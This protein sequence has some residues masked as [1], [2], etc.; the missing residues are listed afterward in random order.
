MTALP[1]IK[2]G[3][4]GRNRTDM[5]LRALDFESAALNIKP[6]IFNYYFYITDPMCKECERL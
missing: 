5:P 4:R 1:P 2:T 6:L 3:A